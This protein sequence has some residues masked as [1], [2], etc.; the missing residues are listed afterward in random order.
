MPNDR[1]PEQRPTPTPTERRDI[2]HSGE[3]ADGRRSIGQDSVQP[4]LPVRD[5]AP[6]PQDAPP[7]DRNPNQGES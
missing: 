3:K 1:K 5:E 4:S 7:R 2:S 6:P